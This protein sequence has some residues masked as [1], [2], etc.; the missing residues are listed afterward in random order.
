MAFTEFFIVAVMVLIVFMFVRQ[1]YTEVSM[2]KGP[3]GRRYVVRNLP[4][5]KRAA[6]ILSS[7]NAKL[8]RL[9]A[10]MERRYPDDPATAQ[11]AQNYNPDAISEGGSEVGYTSYSVNK[12]EKIVLCIRQSD[13]SFVDENVLIYVAVHELAHLMTD[14]IGH[15]PKFWK[16]FKR[17]IGEAVDIGMYVKVDFEKSPQPYCGIKIASSV[18]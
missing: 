14:E 12:G 1:H 15:T 9:I 4:D 6:R 3:D 7:I 13:G 11:L 17:I 10:H 2:V 16:N 5:A 18:I 8:V